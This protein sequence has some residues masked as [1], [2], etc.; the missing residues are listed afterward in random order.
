MISFNSIRRAGLRSHQGSQC[1][2]ETPS[3]ILNH[4]DSGA[5]WLPFALL[6]KK[7]SHRWSIE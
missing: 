4:T 3:P 2:P 6:E 5:C 7:G 1:A